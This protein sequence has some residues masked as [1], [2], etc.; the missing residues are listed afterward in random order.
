[1]SSNDDE[2]SGTGI[3]QWSIAVDQM[4]V[5]TLAMSWLTMAGYGG[6]MMRTITNIKIISTYVGNILYM[7]LFSR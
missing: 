7:L 6:P 5:G 2:G 1:M 3:G 4:M